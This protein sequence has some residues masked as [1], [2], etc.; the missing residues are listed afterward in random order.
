M[1]VTLYEQMV[2]GTSNTLPQRNIL[3]PVDLKCLDEFDSR[4]I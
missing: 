4:C 1:P 2:Q 3:M